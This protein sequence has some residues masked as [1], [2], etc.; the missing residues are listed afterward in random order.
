MALRKRLLFA[1]VLLVTLIVVSMTGYR[2]L[3]GD[4]VTIL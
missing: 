3:G 4:S 2:V 1:L